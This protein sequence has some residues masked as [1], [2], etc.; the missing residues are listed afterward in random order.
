MSLWDQGAV[1]AQRIEVRD[2]YL[3]ERARVAAIPPTSG[4]PSVTPRSYRPAERRR[5][6]AP[7]DLPFETLNAYTLFG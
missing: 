7:R 2:R 5:Q 1:E 3:A 4:P 6:S